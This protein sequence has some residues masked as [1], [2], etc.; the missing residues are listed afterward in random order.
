MRIHMNQKIICIGG[1]NIDFKLKSQQPIVLCT[2][3]PISSSYSF[4]GVA[5]N[6]AHNLAC[7][8]KNIH[9]QCVVGNDAYG[10]NLLAHMNSLG[11]HVTHSVIKQ[12]KRTSQYH[13]ILDEQG[14]LFLGL[15]DMGIYDE[16]D[17]SFITDS[18]SSW[19]KNSMVFLDT[20][21]PEALIEL[22]LHQARLRQLMVCI[23]P[24]SVEKAKRIP[25][26]LSAVFL[27]KPDLKEASV[28]TDIAINSVD[29]CIDA[30]LKLKERGAKNVVIS[31]GQLGYV[32]VNDDHE[33]HIKTETVTA[34][35]DV[36]GAGDAFIAGILFGLQQKQNILEACQLGAQ[37]AVKTIQSADTVVG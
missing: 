26:D 20:N 5:R 25:Y 19:E 17:N 30:G 21:L 15:A 33:V 23:D 13:A 14:E 16:L 11:V 8:T 28:L 37:L 4:G 34:I 7:L 36:S 27:I 12:N 31:L 22:I 35:T 24:V 18:C 10:R 29:D 1:A 9:L 32:V 2:S 6:V 3:N